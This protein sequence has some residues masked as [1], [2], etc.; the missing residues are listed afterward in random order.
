VNIAIV[1]TCFTLVPLISKDPNI[2][3]Y[4]DIYSTLFE[5]VVWILLDLVRLMWF[6]LLLQFF[7]VLIAVVLNFIRFGGLEDLLPTFFLQ[8]N[9]EPTPRGA[10][11]LELFPAKGFAHSE[12]H[13]DPLVANRA[14]MWLL[15]NDMHDPAHAEAERG[16]QQGLRR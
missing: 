12:I 15:A 11:E 6:L 14:A 2:K 4:F 7:L 3:H 16:A 10:W 13:Q 8:V 9:V 1:V 5:A